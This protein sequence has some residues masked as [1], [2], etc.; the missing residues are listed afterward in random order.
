VLEAGRLGTLT[1][2]FYASRRTGL[3][4]VPTAAGGWE[5]AAGATAL[6][7]LIAGVRRGA[8]VDRLSMGN[9]AANGDFSGV[10]KNSFLIEGGE[11]GPALSEVMVT[12]NM[13]QMLLAVSAVSRERIDTGALCLPWLRIGGA[14]FS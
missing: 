1:P 2:G 4:H 13:A 8:L 5:L 11:V 14:H 7:T 3:P 12:G 9:P 6:E 10:V